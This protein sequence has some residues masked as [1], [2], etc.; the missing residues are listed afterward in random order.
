MF[1]NKL[2]EITKTQGGGG[3]GD[4]STFLNKVRALGE[5]HLEGL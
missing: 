1:K 5:K 3:G 2:I 4:E